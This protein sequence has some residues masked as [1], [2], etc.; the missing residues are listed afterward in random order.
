MGR[1]EIER[2]ERERHRDG[3]ILRS[4]ARY[5][6]EVRL[7]MMFGD[8]DDDDD[9]DESAGP[10]EREILEIFR[11]DDNHDHAAAAALHNSHKNTRT[12]HTQQTLFFST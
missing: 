1:V 4:R 12:K 6:R 10:R 11:D 3:E 9:D 2:R 5:S 7:N 8:D